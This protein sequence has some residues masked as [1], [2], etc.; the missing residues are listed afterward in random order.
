MLATRSPSERPGTV[1][2]AAAYCLTSQTSHDNT[3][4]TLSFTSRRVKKVIWD[5][6]GNE[7]L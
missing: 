3:G 2:N 6:T 1:N 5:M 4:R 7:V